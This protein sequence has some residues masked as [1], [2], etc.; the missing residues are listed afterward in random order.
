MLKADLENYAVSFFNSY[1]MDSRSLEDQAMELYDKLEATGL[2]PRYIDVL[3][4]RH[5]FN[6]SLYEIAKRFSLVGDAGVQKAHLMLKKAH[7]ILKKRGT[8]NE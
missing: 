2:S 1:G 7:E 4:A 5:V 8:I 6:L 3:I